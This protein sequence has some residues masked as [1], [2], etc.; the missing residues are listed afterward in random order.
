MNK[1]EL[2]KKLQQPYETDNW[3]EIIDFVFPNVSYIQS[4]P[5]IPVDN[6]KVEAF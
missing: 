5:D 4:P 1:T 3:K 2:Q 6:E